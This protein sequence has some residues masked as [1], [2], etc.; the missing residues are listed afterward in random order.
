M[1]IRMVTVV[2]WWLL[3]CG[4]AFGGGGDWQ[5]VSVKRDHYL[6]ISS[7]CSSL[8]VA[9]DKALR[10]VICQVLRSIG[11]SYSLKFDSSV[12]MKSG[13]SGDKVSRRMDEKFHYEA[14][15]F[16]SAIEE[17]I[18][19]ASYQRGSGSSGGFVYR[20]LVY[21]PP[22][23]LERARLLSKGAKVIA[24]FVGGD[25]VIE[26]REVNGVGVVLHGYEVRV[27]EKNRHADFLNYYVMSVSSGG[28]RSYERAFPDAVVLDGGG[29]VKQVRL[30]VP[31]NKGGLKG[32]GD[33]LLG[34]SR[35]VMVSLR[36]TDEAGRPLQIPI[37]ARF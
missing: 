17:N 13:S 27:V 14:S 7:P 22:R 37:P 3:F 4:V 18:V 29:R 1:V 23:L 26:V 6:G 24:R 25:G 15:A 28:S 21:F 19:S 10:E 31:T 35:R 33:L 9:R 12:V 20:I 36:G 2:V 32:L 34:T 16:L 11:A 5:S 8:S 30:M